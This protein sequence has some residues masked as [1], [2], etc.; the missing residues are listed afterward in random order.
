MSDHDAFSVDMKETLQ[1]CHYMVKWPANKAGSTQ[2]KMV[3]MPFSM[4]NLMVMVKIHFKTSTQ[5]AILA[6]R[7]DKMYF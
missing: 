3:L 1:K 2:H 6:N 4:K 7:K 5:P